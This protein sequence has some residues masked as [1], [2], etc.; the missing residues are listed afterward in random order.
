MGNWRGGEKIRIWFGPE[1]DLSE[2]YERAD[3]LRTHKEIADHLMQK[4]GELAGSD[5]ERF[6]PNVR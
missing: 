6:G 4:I 2:F 5:R 1:V 3:R